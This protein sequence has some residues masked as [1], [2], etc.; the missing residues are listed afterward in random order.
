MPSTYTLISSNVLTS[1]AASVTFSAIPS[2]YTDLVLRISG[3]TNTINDRQNAF[4]RFNSDA[5]T[6]YS[7]LRLRGDGTTASS[8]LGSNNNEVNFFAALDADNATANT[9]SNWE[10]YIPNYTVSASKPLSSI[11]AQEN[12]NATA[13][14]VAVAGLWRNNAA[15]TSILISA[16]SDSFVSGSS[17]YLYGIKNS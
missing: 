1:S 4:I 12:N 9:F 10:V 7:W 14:I 15:I 17:F 13:N 6:N 2:T 5:A 3:R 11:S 8:T 16:Q